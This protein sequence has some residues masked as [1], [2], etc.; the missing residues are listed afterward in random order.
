VFDQN[1]HNYSS[2]AVQRL[3]ELVE[4]KKIKIYLTTI[5]TREVEA[6]IK[7]SVEEAQANIQAA[8][9]KHRFLKNS[10]LTSIASVFG[11][12]NVKEVIDE[13]KGKFKNWM[14]EM[15]VELIP[16]EGLPIEEIF[17]KYFG[18]HP[19]FNEKKKKEFPDAFT[20][21]ALEKWCKEN[22][23]K[24]YVISSD[25]DMSSACNAS[26]FLKSVKSLPQFLDLLTKGEKLAEFAYSLFEKYRSSIIT[27]LRQTIHMYW[28]WS[29]NPGEHFVQSHVESISLPE[30]YLIEVEEGKAIFEVLVKATHSAEIIKTN[31]LMMN[32]GVRGYQETVRRDQFLKAEISLLFDKEDESKFQ[33]EYAT[34]KEEAVPYYHQYST[35]PD[36]Y[37]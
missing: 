28:Y 36:I 5:T 29:M 22:K 8:L 19:P 26:A 12:I 3:K 33:V 35:Y 15:S 4:D 9:T 27:R 25:G 20:I 7:E 10:N 37:S 13:L 6:H 14:S 23:A 18:R 34:I 16:I 24:M 17:D 2:T 11:G 1:S 31:L 32:M 21:L 30:K